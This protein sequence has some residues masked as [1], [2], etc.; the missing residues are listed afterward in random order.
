M[1]PNTVQSFSRLNPNGQIKYSGYIVNKNENFSLICLK[2]ESDSVIL[3]LEKYIISEDV[4][5]KLNSYSKIFF[6]NEIQ[7][8]DSIPGVFSFIPGFFTF[9]GSDLKVGEFIDQ[10][11]YQ[12]LFSLNDK[13]LFPESLGVIFSSHMD[14]GCYV[15][16][17][18]ISKIENNPRTRR[19]PL[20][21]EVVGDSK[22][23]AENVENKEI[24]N[25]QIEFGK[26]IRKQVIDSSTYLLVNAKRESQLDKIN[27][28]LNTNGVSFTCN[29]INLKEF[30]TQKYLNDSK[31][32]FYQGVDS[33]NEDDDG[34]AKKYFSLSLILDSKNIDSLEALGVLLGRNKNYQ[35]AHELMDQLLFYDPGSIMAHTNKSLFY[36]N[37]GKIEEAEKEKEFALKK[38]LNSSLPHNEAVNQHE[39]REQ[40]LRKQLEM[41]AE[42]LEIDFEDD[43]ATQ[44]WLEISFEL[45]NY[46]EMEV[47]LNRREWDKNLKLFLWKHKLLVELGDVEE[48]SN[49]VPSMVE[50]ALKTGDSKAVKYLKKYLRP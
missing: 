14:K 10:S 42:V 41:Y 7:N 28:E 40:K 27:I 12:S 1:L 26:I 19:F 4:E 5:L 31:N 25:G 50:L 6:S 16:Q 24:Y 30:L 22:L 13:G 35:L 34:L 9:S 37:E 18:V 21:L 47:F 44:K 48:L 43:F 23:F 39:E 46:E 20:I 17:E 3:D 8:I 15:G 49:D 38:S 36:M 32:Y 29:S 45:N 33:L 2:Q 11:E